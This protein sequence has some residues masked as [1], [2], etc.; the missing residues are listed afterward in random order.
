MPRI[1][2]AA[3]TSNFAIGF[4]ALGMALNLYNEYEF[5][6]ADH[7]S[8]VGF[9]EAY[10]TNNLV[11]KSYQDF[12]LDNG[13]TSKEMKKVK[14]TL[15]LQE[16]PIERGLGSSAACIIAGVLA[17]NIIHDLHYTLS[18]VAAYASRV[19]GHPDNVYSAVF[20]GLNATFKE[21]NQYINESL[22]VHKDLAFALLIP[23]TKGNTEA[24][25]EALPKQVP[26]KDAVFHLSR[27]LQLPHALATANFEKLKFLIQ[28]KL[29]EVYRKAQ[30]PAY[31]L[32]KQLAK[33]IGVISFI[34]GS[35]PSMFLIRDTFDFTEF[36]VLKEHFNMVP[37]GIGKGVIVI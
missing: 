18:E 11:L 2:V 35:G 26:L 1:K 6:E 3:T 14:I 4:D 19:E 21:E 23:N 15:I 28:D 9:D 12:C 31:D 27:S 22:S 33:R 5:K 24:L 20:G 7:F 13:L 30:I 16:I 10:M 29:H 34:S 17:A 36:N 37:V 32:V 8:L 25:R